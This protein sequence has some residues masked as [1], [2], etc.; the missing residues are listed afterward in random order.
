MLESQPQA[1]T[2][3]KVKLSNPIDMLRAFDPSSPIGQDQP[4]DTFTDAEFKGF[5]EIAPMLMGIVELIPNDVLHITCNARTALYLG[6]SPGKMNNIKMSTLGL[7][8]ALIEKW[9]NRY[10][11]AQLRGT[12]V[13]Y[14]QFQAGQ[15][16]KV[17]SVTV[18]HIGKGPTGNER[19]IY[20]LED[21]RTE[22]ELK[23][24]QDS[25]VFALESARMGTWEIDL[26]NDQVHCSPEMLALWNIDPISFAG[27][28]SLLQSKMHPEDLPTMRGVMDAAIEKGEIYECEFRIIPRPGEVRWIN[29]R[30]RC[31]YDAG[32]DKPTRFSGVAFEI[33]A[34]RQ[35]IDVAKNAT[36]ARDNM[37]SISAHE[38]ITPISGAKLLLQMLKKR[39]EKGEELS[40]EV[41]I[42]IASQTDHS[43]NRL[44]KLVNDMLDISRLNLGKFTLKRERVNLS[45]LVNDTIESSMAAIEASG[46]TAEIKIEPKIEAWVDSYK[47]EQVL[48][49][50]ISNACRYAPGKPIQITLLTTGETVRLSV[51]DEGVGIAAK[52]HLRIFERFE[53]ASTLNEGAGLGLGLFLVKQIVD[54]HEGNVFLESQLGKGANFTVELPLDKRASQ[55]GESS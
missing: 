35:A 23:R 19:F 5:F 2:W 43:L 39:L 11:E 24:S 28:R 50:L 29:S 53:R 14:E 44:T 40:R 38:L 15:M 8:P 17:F 13:Q 21:K 27:Q 32:T 3:A 12:P 1:R 55:N 25:L 16:A 22:L 54:A 36:K 41:L 37:I 30:G 9:T 42:K 20:L 45:A 34:Q 26:L 31:M 10:R 49:N 33:T 7:S 52:D 48:S 46:C 47:I 18:K 4:V 51:R 6:V